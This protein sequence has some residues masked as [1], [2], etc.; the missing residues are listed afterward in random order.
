MKPRYYQWP[1]KRQSMKRIKMRLRIGFKLGYVECARCF[2]YGPVCLCKGARLL[3]AHDRRATTVA[4]GIADAADEREH[5]D[6]CDG[7]DAPSCFCWCD[8]AYD[9]ADDVDLTVPP[10]T[11]RV[12]FASS[13]SM[14]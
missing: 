7:C 6:E 1:R 10:L 9:L 5:A 4:E 11:M 8:L 14:R 3:S 2:Y 12:L 13:P